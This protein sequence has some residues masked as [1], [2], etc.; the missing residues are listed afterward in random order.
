M[1][2]MQSFREWLSAVNAAST[3]IQ[4]RLAALTRFDRK[5]LANAAYEPW[6]L[7]NAAEPASIL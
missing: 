6:F 3:P 5:R 1:K 2:Q 7:W 4:R